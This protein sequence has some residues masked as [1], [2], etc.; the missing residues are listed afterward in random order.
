MPVINS[1]ARFA[2]DKRPGYGSFTLM[3]FD[4]VKLLGDGYTNGL[5]LLI[6]RS[7]SKDDEPLADFQ[8]TDAQGFLTIRPTH[9]QKRGLDFVFDVGPE[10]VN[11]MAY[12]NSGDYVLQLKGLYGNILSFKVSLIGQPRASVQF[13]PQPTARP[14][15]KAKAPDDPSFVTGNKGAAGLSGLAGAPNAAGAGA[16]VSGA[17]QKITPRD[18]AARREQEEAERQ[19]RVRSGAGMVKLLG[20]LGVLIVLGLLIFFF[21]D[22]IFGTGS[23]SIASNDTPPAQEAS[24]EQAPEPAPEPEPESA[25]EPEMA[26]APDSAPVEVQVESVLTPAQQNCRIVAGAGDDRTIINKCLA[27]KPTDNDLQHL[28]AESMKA[29]RCEIALRILRTKGR[30]VNGGAF[31]YVYALYADPKSTYTSPCISKSAEDAEYWAGRVSQDRNFTEAQG[32]ELL[33]QLRGQ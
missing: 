9:C 15:F 18:A 21:K 25:P 11:P 6:K 29:E 32:Q 2:P 27:S 24:V 33:E 5:S 3:H 23:T 30:A 22:L 26:S 16:S 14:S 1:F 10:V 4:P 31:A 12:D 20:I 8:G 28:L 17:A 13:G 7:S 19:A